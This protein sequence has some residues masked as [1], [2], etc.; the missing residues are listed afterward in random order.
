MNSSESNLSTLTAVRVRE[1]IY[2]K[3]QNF[4][5]YRQELLPI[6]TLV[7]YI[8]NIILQ[9]VLQTLIIFMKSINKFI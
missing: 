9:N 8:L 7:I 3:K 1:Y 5:E 6:F 4:Q 2:S